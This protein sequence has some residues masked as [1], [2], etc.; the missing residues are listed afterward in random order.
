[1]YKYDFV[2]IEIKLKKDGDMLVLFLQ[3]KEVLDIFKN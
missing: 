1:M 3:N 2:K